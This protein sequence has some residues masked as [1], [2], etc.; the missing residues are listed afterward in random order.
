LPMRNLLLDNGCASR[1]GLTP[2]PT[3]LPGQGGSRKGMRP[4]GNE[5]G[6]A[7]SSALLGQTDG[8]SF[9]S[10]KRETKV[11]SDGGPEL[12]SAGVPW[13]EVPEFARVH[14]AWIDGRHGSAQSSLPPV[15]VVPVPDILYTLP[16]LHELPG[17]KLPSIFRS[18]GPS[19]RCAPRSR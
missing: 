12:T 11:A 4:F 1:V 5:T 18:G 10:K 7:N 6:R 15:D 3:C 16:Y 14:V 9:M 17:L 8:G 13:S 19:S 2:S